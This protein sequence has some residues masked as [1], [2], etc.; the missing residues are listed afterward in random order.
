M[1]LY[2]A[3]KQQKGQPFFKLNN[4]MEPETT[5]D[6]KDCRLENNGLIPKTCGFNKSF[7]INIRLTEL[8]DSHIDWCMSNCKKDWGW[9]FDGNDAYISFK[10]K[11]EATMFSL[12][13]R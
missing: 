11:N 3:V 1:F 7:D 12:S 6:F 8:Q 5:W 4:I 9:F 10:S 2:N 13:A